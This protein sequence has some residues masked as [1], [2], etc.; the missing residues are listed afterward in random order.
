M[1][2]TRLAVL[3]SISSVFS[4]FSQK[5]YK[6]SIRNA[7][8]IFIINLNTLHHDIKQSNTIGRLHRA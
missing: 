8:V 3:I 2:Q 4:V 6:K 5:D 7:A 1:R